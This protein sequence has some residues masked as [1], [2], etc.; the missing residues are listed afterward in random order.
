MGQSAE[1]VAQI[2]GAG[3]QI[4]ARL[5][6]MQTA[7]EKVSNGEKDILSETNTVKDSMSNIS[8]ISAKVG[9][10]STLIRGKSDALKQGLEQMNSTLENNMVNVDEVEKSLSIFKT[11]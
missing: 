3:S 9:D 1:K 10:A 5:A 4:N 6:A 7:I 2:A 8:A 11:K